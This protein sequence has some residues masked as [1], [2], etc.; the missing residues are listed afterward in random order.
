M[1]NASDAKEDD[2]E[3]KN[4]VDLMFEKLAKKDPEHFAVL[5][6]TKDKA[7][8]DKPGKNFNKK[9]M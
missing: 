3:H 4:A 8:Q 9:H 1:L 6:Y 7:P 2:E 5:Q